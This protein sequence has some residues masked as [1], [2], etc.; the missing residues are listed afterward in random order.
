MYMSKRVIAIIICI[1][2]ILLIGGG[3]YYVIRE[4]KPQNIDNP[5]GNV[6]K[7]ENKPNEEPIDKSDEEEEKPIEETPKEEENNNSG[8]IIVWNPSNNSN[9]GNNSVNNPVYVPNTDFLNEALKL[10]SDYYNSSTSNEELNNFLEILKS[11]YNKASEKLSSTTQTV[12]DEACKELQ[13]ALKN[14][15]DK[16]E[17]VDKKAKEALLLSE[18]ENTKENID[19]ALAYINLMMNGSLQEEYRSRA[20][21]TTSPV[22]AVE[23]GEFI[24]GKDGYKA[25]ELTI[26]DNYDEDITS[27]I[28]EISYYHYNNGTYIAVAPFPMNNTLEDYEPGEYRVR[29]EITDSAGNKGMKEQTIYLYD[30]T[31]PIINITY[32]TDKYT[33]KEVVV[34]VKA[35]EKLNPL[36]GWNLDSSKT[37]LTKIYQTNTEEKIIVSDIYQ[38]ET[39]A[40]IKIENI[41]V[42]APSYEIYDEYQR[43]DTYGSI[44]LKIKDNVEIATITINGDEKEI[45]K[46]NTSLDNGN[47]QNG[48]NKIEIADIAGNKTIFIFSYSKESL[49]DAINSLEDFATLELT[50]VIKEDITIKNSNVTI[51]GN[52]NTV[53]SGVV[54]VTGE[55]VV[56]D[57]IIFDN[58]VDQTGKVVVNVMNEGDFTLTNSTFKN[59][60]T[61]TYNVLK[62]ASSGKVVIENNKFIDATGVYNTIE[63]SQDKKYAL[64]N[65][66]SIKNNYFGRSATNN[67][68]NI[69]EVE[70]GATIK[71]EGNTFEY[72]SNAIR[73][74]NYSNTSATFEIKDNTILDGDHGVYE[75]VILLQAPT[76]TLESFKTYTINITNLMGPD[77]TQ[78]L[79]N[80]GDVL[81]AYYYYGDKHPKPLEFPDELKATINF[82]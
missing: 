61:K 45:H 7:E 81:R 36:E 66:S 2:G 18:K 25:S 70:D 51:K 72:I 65:G 75:G 37:E 49:S 19:Q 44:K 29:Y 23:D 52:G 28:V 16:V 46:N 43:N 71:I 10:A 47:W 67:N 62:I 74:S 6:E 12:I 57:N 55:N 9:S 21:D 60:K 63:F 38:N 73:L 33:N 68:I 17:E 58:V 31:S 54:K 78:I 3:I 39:E 35:N 5:T 22:I 40:T 80:S 30:K 48:V 76:S 50:G 59:I 4:D 24:I 1:L 69:F 15:T 26:T 27:K 41:D 32:S 34:R 42:E 77:N 14:L 20:K 56:L 53:L 11:I 79:D 13:I 82:K 8:T 64:K